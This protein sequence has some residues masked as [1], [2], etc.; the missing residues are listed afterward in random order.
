MQ[1]TAKR[2]KSAVKNT[3][4]ENAARSAPA[5]RNDDLQSAIY[6]CTEIVNFNSWLVSVNTVRMQL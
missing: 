6:D 4:K 5:A 3:R 2:K 1:K